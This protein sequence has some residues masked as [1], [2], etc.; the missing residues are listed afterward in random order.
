LKADIRHRKAVVAT[1]PFELLIGGRLTYKEKPHQS[2]LSGQKREPSLFARRTL[3]DVTAPTVKREI[4]KS[5]L[6]PLMPS[7]S[8]NDVVRLKLE[9]STTFAAC[10]R[11]RVEPGLYGLPSFAF[12]II[13]LHFRP[14]GQLGADL[15][16]VEMTKNKRGCVLPGYE[17]TSDEIDEELSPPLLR[18]LA[19]G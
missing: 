7:L 3:N 15:R 10:P 13:R 9:A 5:V 16:R 4:V 8:G 2:G 11:L 18:P 17:S 19:I 14:G 12:P 6:A 1:K